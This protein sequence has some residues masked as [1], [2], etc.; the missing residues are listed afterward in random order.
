MDEFECFAD[1]NRDGKVDGFELAL[2]FHMMAEEDREL[3]RLL[4]PD[5]D[6]DDEDDEPDDF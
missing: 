1:F 6:L 4:H 5:L 3:E 2:A